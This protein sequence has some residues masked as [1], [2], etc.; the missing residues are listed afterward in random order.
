MAKK[1]SF[2]TFSLSFLDIMS[3]GFGAVVLVFLII[4]HDVDVKVEVENELMLAEVNLLAEDIREGEEQLVRLKNT[5]SELDQKLVTAQGLARR[6]NDDIDAVRNK[7]DQLSLD[8]DDQDIKKLKQELKTLQDEKRKLE[9][10]KEQGNEVRRFIGQGDRQYLTGMNLGGRRV[11]IL[12][13]VSTSML[14]DS[15]VNILR[16]RYMSDETKRSA[17]KWQRAVMTVEWLISQLPIDS[18]Y[19]I[20]GFNTQARALLENTTGQWLV[21]DNR[22]QI[23]QSVL[24]L[25]KIVPDKGTSLIRAF[26]SVAQLNPM[27]DNIFLITD[28]LPTQGINRPE[29]TTV[30]AKQRLAYFKSAVEVLPVGIPVNVLLWPMEGDPMAAAAFWRLAQMSAGSFISPSKDWP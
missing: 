17:K 13:D 18:R 28:G 1:R 24:A 19:Q 30:D 15:I 26:H 11:L 20:Y 10:E 5:V 29:T 7:M 25:R 22:E 2:S 21:T 23:E 4:K 16:R 12:L 3:C 6:I 14:D 8:E 27:P 9:D